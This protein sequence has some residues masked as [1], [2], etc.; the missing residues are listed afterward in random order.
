MEE[1]A[2]PAPKPAVFCEPGR[3]SENGSRWFPMSSI[4]KPPDTKGSMI[5]P[6]GRMV[7]PSGSQGDGELYTLAVAGDRAAAQQLVS[8][9]HADLL[10]YLRAKTNA[11]VVAEDAVAEAWLRFF[12]HLKEAAQ[13]PAR[14]LNKP[15][16]LRFWL[17]RTAVNAMRD[18]FRS[19]SRQA[20]LSDRV[21]TEA[22]ARGLTAY[23]PDELAALEDEERRS[24]IRAAFHKLSD[25]CRELLTLMS[26]DPPLSY[27]EV[28]EVVDRPVGSLG[29]TRKRCLDDLRRHLG[30]AA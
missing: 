21:T 11:H 3:R 27:K 18:Q 22:A 15:E 9:Y 28:A 2:V 6:G 1:L 5:V 30:G 13:D 23:H 12:R 26:A 20:D 29:P 19:S 24:A 16:S 8:R 4:S 7:A 14:S 25:T 17:Y 10:L